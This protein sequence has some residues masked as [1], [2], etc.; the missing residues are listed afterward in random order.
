MKED[1]SKKAIGLAIAGVLAGSGLVAAQTK[2]DGA[3]Q[4]TPKATKDKRPRI[5]IAAL[6]RTAARPSPARSRPQR[7]T[8]TCARA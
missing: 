6:A 7:P 2:G 3:K 8:S 4:K 5:R 1:L